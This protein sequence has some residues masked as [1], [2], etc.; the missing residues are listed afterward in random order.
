MELTHIYSNSS[1]FTKSAGSQVIDFSSFTDNNSSPFTFTKL[2]GIFQKSTNKRFFNSANNSTFGSIS[3]NQITITDTA[4]SAVPASDILI[5]YGDDVVMLNTTGLAIVAAINSSNNFAETVW[6]DSANT[7]NFYVRDVSWFDSSSSYTV[8]FWDINRTTQLTNS[9]I[10]SRLV[11]AITSTDYEIVT[12]DYKVIN[13]FT[14]ANVG[15]WIKQINIINTSSTSPAITATIWKNFSTNS[16]LS[17]A[18]TLSNLQV[19]GDT[20]YTNG[21]QKTQ[22]VDSSGANT[23]AIGSA[24][25]IIISG[26]SAVGATPTLNPI[27]VSGVDSG[28]LKRHFLTKT[29]GTV[30]TET[31]VIGAGGNTITSTTIGAKER[32]DVILAT[33]TTINTTPNSTVDM[34]GGVDPSNNAQ[35]LQLDTNK[36]LLS[37]SQVQFPQILSYPPQNF[38]TATGT[39]QYSIVPNGLYSFCIS[40][41]NAILGATSNTIASCTTTAYTYGNYSAATTIA[42]T[43]N[44]AGLQIGQLLSGT[45]IAVGTYVTSVTNGTGFT[46]SQPAIASG[47][48]TLNVTAGFFAGTFQS[49]PDNATWNNISVTP[50][51]YQIAS[52]PTLSFTSVGL[53]KYQASNADKF[54]RFNLTSIGLTGVV[55]NLTSLRLR[56]NIDSLDRL[57]SKINLPYISYIAATAAT[58]P[59]GIPAL[60]PISTEYL[61]EIIFDNTAFAGTSQ[62]IT[63]KESND[64]NGILFNSVSALQ[65]NTLA[66]TYIL[67]TSSTGTYRITPTGKY[68]YI[69]LTNGSAVTSNTISGCTATV[70]YQPATNF[71]F[72]GGNVG[73]GAAPSSSPLFIGGSDLANLTRKIT[74]STGGGLTGIGEIVELINT[75]TAGATIPSEG[76]NCRTFQSIL[77]KDCD[78]YLGIANQGNGAN[79]IQIEGSYDNQI[80]SV[81]PI[82]RVD[83]LA[84]YSVG[85][86]GN[87]INTAQATGDITPVTGAV[88]KGR[89]YGYNYIRVHQTAFTTTGTNGTL[90]IVPLQDDNDGSI[91]S[92]FTLDSGATGVVEAAGTANGIM[93]VGGVKTLNTR[94]MTR[95]QLYLDALTYAT[96]APTS[97]TL[98]VEGSNDPTFSTG[99]WVALPLQPRG[100]GATVTS[101][102]TTPPAIGQW[103]GGQYEFDCSL[104]GFVRVRWSTFTMGTA[105]QTRYHGALKLLTGNPY[106]PQRKRTYSTAFSVV[107]AA[108]ATDIFQ[109]IG[110]AS[111]VVEV[112]KIVISGTQ[113][114]SGLNNVF[115]SK[116]STANT[117]GTSTSAVLVPNNAVDA[118]ATAVGTIYTANP[119]A[120]GTAVGDLEILSVPFN[121]TTATTNNIVERRF[122]ANGKPLILNGVAQAI[123]IRLNGVTITGGSINI[124]IEFNEY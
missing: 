44:I 111:A 76:T 30:K 34:F 4:F 10:I 81:I 120:V 1:G 3:G 35:F 61:S 118:A 82:S 52:G 56:F 17:S 33:A 48:I 45:N 49:S 121:S 59:T 16:T 28:G 86:S 94:G 101:I 85:V 23:L 77:N 60:Y 41:D 7:S 62:A 20:V 55:T 102:T 88:Y 5:S 79:K 103:L 97:S 65:T 15:D 91:S 123:A 19:F 78:V 113:T 84:A 11:Q 13:A 73:V 108:S 75:F 107:P 8:T 22:I 12:Q 83:N 122:G 53:W 117:G 36:R 9:V 66:S 99:I 2:V 112:T 93:Q 26:A 115:I 57:G 40:I 21:T 6:Y 114:T 58:F 46:I 74:Q 39:V 92:A 31:T 90:R 71:S 124:S 105:T 25:N 27:S 43:T 104:Y 32:L 37:S 106:S 72:T 24:G 80:F 119:S 67:T 51:T 70:G 110:S 87:Y 98:V 54:L 96:A 14:G 69:A 38:L 95:G 63:F 29:D 64:D 47:T 42:T 116:R 89:S 109:L 50:L 100:G 18:P 68:F